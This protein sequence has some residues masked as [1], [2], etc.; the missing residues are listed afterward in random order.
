MAFQ[1]SEPFNHALERSSRLP[2][3]VFLDSTASDEFDHMTRSRFCSYGAEGAAALST[4]RWNGE[5]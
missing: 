2:R 1:H 4:Y 3:P 5:G